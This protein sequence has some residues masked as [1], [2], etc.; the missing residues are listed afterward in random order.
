MEF[1]VGTFDPLNED[2]VAAG[3]PFDLRLR[4]RVAEQGER[5]PNGYSAVAEFEP[6]AA[7]VVPELRR[8]R[9]PCFTKVVRRGW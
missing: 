8:D 9:V 7:P 2:V 4:D 6:V 3:I 1:D 5:F